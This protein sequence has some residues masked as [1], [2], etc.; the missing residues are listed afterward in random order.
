MSSMNTVAAQIKSL[1][2][3]VNQVVSDY[4]VLKA[5]NKELEEK[6]SELEAN[7]QNCRSELQQKQEEIERL[8]LAKGLSGSP[9][10]AAMAKARLG[11]LMREI[12]RCIALLNE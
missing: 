11:S 2:N 6:L 12:D 1:E 3:R 5:R 10:E 4:L 8:K 9:E 7:H